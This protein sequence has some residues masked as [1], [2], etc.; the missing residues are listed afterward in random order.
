MQYHKPAIETPA[1]GSRR[2]LSAL[3]DSI[4]ARLATDAALSDSNIHE[5]RKT[6]KKLRAVLRIIRPA[7]EDGNFRALDRM[8]RDLARQLAGMRDTRVMRDTLDLLGQHFAPVL[9]AQALA[10]V[11]A[12]LGQGTAKHVGAAAVLPD[13]AALRARLTEITA[14]A[15][16]AD[17]DR[18]GTATLLDGLETIYRCGRR[19]LRRMEAS[20]DTENGHGLRRQAKYQ[21]YQLRT[22][23]SWNDTALKPLIDGFHRLEELLG[24]DHDLAVLGETLGK[25]PQLCPDKVRRELLHAL[26]ESRRIA[27]MTRALRLARQLYRSKPGRYRQQLK[28]AFLQPA[29]S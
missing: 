5:I 1:A 13:A 4:G 21:Y 10:P 25:Q 12:A 3:L 24:K 28:R 26:I 14:A 15:A 19:A 6:C 20:P 9:H 17:Y 11:H 2:I 7:L 29:L 8:I 16:Q 22:L 18:I 23:G 27:L